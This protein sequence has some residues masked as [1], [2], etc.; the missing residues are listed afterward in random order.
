MAASAPEL[1]SDYHLVKLGDVDSTNLEAK[2]QAELGAPDKTLVWASSQSAGRGR[3]GRAWSSPE[4]NTYFSILLR[5]DGNGANAMQ[6]GFV[7]ANAIAK[8][9]S[10]I[11]PNETK[12]ETKWPNDVL[13]NGK[14]ISGIL[15]ESE[16]DSDAK[17]LKWLIIGVGIN[18]SAHPG[19]G[20]G[21]TITTSL[22]DE[23]LINQPT[24]ISSILGTIVR[25]FDAGL[26]VWKK[27]GF[28]PVRE[29]WLARAAGLSKE[30]IVRLPN[31]TISGTFKELD[32]NGA[33][34]LGLDDANTRLI[35]AGDV[36]L[37]HDH[38]EMD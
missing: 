28:A 37:S 7:M 32:E 24:L 6:L 26:A 17:S 8:S 4:G 20:E 9:I 25:N 5:P 38:D 1:P 27:D 12:V 10:A 30:I 16:I 34:V 18:I 13:V 3:R 21:N 23:G 19:H 15:M 36:F 14:K 33:L 11:L 2:R 31:E 22:I 35:T 29:T